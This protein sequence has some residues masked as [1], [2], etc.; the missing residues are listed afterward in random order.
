MTI[1]RNDKHNNFHLIDSIDEAM[2]PC[3]FAAPSVFWLSFQWLGMSKTCLGM[4]L[5]FRNKA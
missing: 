1:S 5:E 3:E 4:V 2:L